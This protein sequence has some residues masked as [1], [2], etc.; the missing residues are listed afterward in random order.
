MHRAATLGYCFG[1]CFARDSLRAAEA[2]RLVWVRNDRIAPL[3]ALV[4]PAP[5]PGGRAVLAVSFGESDED[6][7]RWLAIALAHH[8]L[9]HRSVTAYLYGEHGPLFAKLAERDDAIEFAE[10][11]LNATREYK[12]ADS[13]V[14]VLLGEPTAPNS[15]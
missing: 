7:Q 9:G 14:P 4:L 10:S 8:V 13:E 3:R 11:F 6:L 5:E 15:R 2:A 12:P 1:L